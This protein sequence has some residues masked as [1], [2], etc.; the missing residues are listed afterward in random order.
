MAD[1]V[2]AIQISSSPAEIYPLISTAL[3]LTEWWAADVTEPEGAVELG[4]FK[5]STVYRL[6]NQSNHPPDRVEWRCE[7]GEEWSGTRLKF[8]LE[9]A[10]AGTL[11][12]FTHA[13]WPS[14]SAYFISCNT[15]WG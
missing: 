14:E 9:A 6:R 8:Y 15:T 7:T 12:R 13:D 5:R 10:G 3:G 11:L 2:H 4:F 1:I